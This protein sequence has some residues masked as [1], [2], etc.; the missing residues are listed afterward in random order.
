MDKILT[1]KREKLYSFI[2][3]VPIVA[4]IIAGTLIY[5]SHFNKGPEITLILSKA[6]GIEAGKTAIKALSVNVGKIESIS[7]SQDR[8]NVVAI[9][10]MNPGT[11]D[12]VRD[13]SRFWI[14]KVRIDRQGVSGLDTLLSGYYIELSPGNSPKPSRMFTVMD[15]PPLATDDKG[16]YLTLHSESLKKVSP[17]SALKFKGIEAGHVLDANYDFEKQIMSY[18]VF[19]AEPYASIIDSGTKF[20]ISSGITF[21]MGP[22]GLKVDTD[23]IENIISGGISF[24]NIEGNSLNEDDDVPVHNDHVFV[25]YNDRL[26]IIPTYAQNRTLN[27][28]IFL[29]FPDRGLQAE[30]PVF[31][32]GV[33]VGVVKKMPYFPENYR[34]FHDYSKYTAVLIG[35][36]QERFEKSSLESIEE[37][38]QDID[39]LIK[40]KNLTASVENMNILTGKKCIDLQSDVDPAA[41]R[42][43]FNAPYHGYQVIPSL[44]KS[45]STI[46]DDLSRFTHK[47]ATLPMEDLAN[48]V[49]Q[50][51]KNFQNTA[52]E[53][54]ALTS[55]IN[56]IAEKLHKEN[57]SQEMLNTLKEVQAIMSSYSSDS[58]LYRELS[59]AV[60]E[61]NST[62]KGVKPVVTKVNE[63]TNSLVF[64]YDRQD[65]VP[66]GKKENKKK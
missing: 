34:I 42:L 16:I 9:A 32:K 64:S 49:N 10:R 3:T 33:Q 15:D 24:D 53:I 27:Y 38:R 30:S 56:A 4:L 35:I 25:L 29:P 2:W 44:D 23:S 60:K 12:L 58:A 1:V 5:R 40:N 37:I 51:L 39:N 14:Q 59:L 20:W 48:N 55:N 63:K 28:I 45:F 18:R 54:N 52:L 43:V 62:L 13:D 65:P 31:F 17:G 11:E 8:K 41:N 46:Q 21:S 7:L 22:D 66:A 26:S 36:Q 19:V 47:L 50:L 6:D 57:V 61:L